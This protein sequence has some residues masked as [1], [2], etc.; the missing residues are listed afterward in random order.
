MDL[1]ISLPALVGDGLWRVAG[2]RFICFHS[3]GEAF[4]EWTAGLFADLLGGW[5]GN[6]WFG[7]IHKATSGAGD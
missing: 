3:T 4:G 1:A 2:A 7:R 5:T 6:I